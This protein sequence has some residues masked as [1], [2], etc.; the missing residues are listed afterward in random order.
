[1]TI[2]IHHPYEIFQNKCFYKIEKYI[3]GIENVKFLIKVNRFQS[4]RF[5]FEVC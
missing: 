2:I 4:E 3:V 5:F 1:M